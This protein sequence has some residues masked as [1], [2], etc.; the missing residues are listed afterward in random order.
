MTV[1]INDIEEAAE[2][3]KD[4]AQY[5]P[6]QYSK[7][8]SNKYHANIY[9]KREDLQEVRSFKI[10][11]AYNKMASLSKEEQ[12]KGIVCA[13]AGNHAQGVAYSCAALKIHGVI[14]MPVVTPN[15]K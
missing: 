7:R 11:G 2:R 4:V 12:K 8:L 10:R 3:L 14:F 15:Q 13:S 5:T 1:T 6:L 9:L